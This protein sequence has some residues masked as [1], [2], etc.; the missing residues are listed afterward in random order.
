RFRGKRG[1]HRGRGRLP[2]REHLRHHEVAHAVVGE[3]RER[4]LAHKERTGERE[5]ERDG[6][7]GEVGKRSHPAASVSAPSM[8]FAIRDQENRRACTSPCSTRV[9]RSP[10][11]WTRRIAPCS[12]PSSIGFT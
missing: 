6:P 2:G 11:Y 7:G 5:R 9:A 10:G 3:G 12:A 8:I 4:R 1:A